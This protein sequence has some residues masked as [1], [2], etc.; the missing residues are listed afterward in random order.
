MAEDVNITPVALIEPWMF[1]YPGEGWAL[2]LC[3]CLLIGL[4]VMFSTLDLYLVV[5]LII[6]GLVYVKLR[7]AQYMGDA[8]R[9]HGGQF[10]ELWDIFKKHAETLHITQGALFIKQDPSLNAF[11]L[12][13]T[14]CTVVLT[15]A[16]VEQLN[17]NEL[18]FVIAHELGHYKAGHTKISSLINPLGS[19]N[20][21]A[22][23]IFG[24]WSRK[25]EYSAD[26]CG[27]VL[28]RNL[29]AALG[30]MIK[31]SIGGKLME[32]FDLEGYLSQVKKAD[33][34]STRMGELLIDHPLVTN[35]I[36]Q[37]YTFY[38]ENFIS[39]HEV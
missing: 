28:S 12:G 24:F 35:R 2:L 36:R 4:G 19:G 32:K 27:L 20:V 37:M 34:R 25:T 3:I 14:S 21:F 26:R 22:E 9:I 1:R 7:Q 38:K 15:S 16:L 23:L 5:I 6:G 10:P 13:I 17:K 33:S 11:S 8:I 29:N 18:N 30:A 39:K 31:L